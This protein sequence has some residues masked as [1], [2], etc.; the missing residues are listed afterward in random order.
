MDG[1]LDRSLT[2]LLALL[3]LKKASPVELMTAVIARTEAVEPKIG[4]ESLAFLQYTSGST[5]TPKGVMVSHQNLLHNQEMVRRLA[6][7]GPETK[8]L[9]WTPLYHDMGIM[10]MVLQAL[11]VGATSVLMSP[12]AFLRSPVRWLRA[13]SHFRTN[14]SG[15]P[16]FAFDLCVK[17]ID[18]SET[19]GI[20]LSSWDVA[21]S[22]SEPVRA[23][24]DHKPIPATARLAPATIT[25]RPT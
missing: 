1:L 11:Y 21:F 2:E 17:K 10:I 4:A 6:R 19:A 7:S 16:N 12:L 9:G 20:D 13:I 3:R 14:I 22:S 25:H 15:G 5:S 24:H 18:P 8:L 23:L